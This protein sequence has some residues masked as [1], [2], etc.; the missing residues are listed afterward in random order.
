MLDTALVIAHRLPVDVT[1]SPPRG[2]Y[3]PFRKALVQPPCEE[4]SMITDQEWSALRHLLSNAS[5]GQAEKNSALGYL[6]WQCGASRERL[7]A[8]LERRIAANH[9]RNAWLKGL[10]RSA[11]AEW[12]WP[13]IA[14]VSARGF[15]CLVRFEK[16]LA[17][18]H[19]RE[20]E[21]AE[22]RAVR[23]F[24]AKMRRLADE[25]LDCELRGERFDYRWM[26]QLPR[27]TV[28][29][30]GWATDEDEEEDAEIRARYGIDQHYD[31][32]PRGD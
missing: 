15:T 31:D 18:S 14:T 7:E 20:T 30:G 2:G 32:W 26:D 24:L 3:R 4:R 11:I 10:E 12:N 25:E 22:E 8:L 23:A 17:K 1:F 27:E 5:E 28:T 9:S 6:P 21:E 19:V 13:A 16:P 29:N